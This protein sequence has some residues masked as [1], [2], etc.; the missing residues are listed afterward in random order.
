MIAYNF[1]LTKILDLFI[2]S[3]F[4]LYQVFIYKTCWLISNMLPPLKAVL[5][6][7]KI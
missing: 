3:L 6:A 2:E 5:F 4:L 7:L 1:I